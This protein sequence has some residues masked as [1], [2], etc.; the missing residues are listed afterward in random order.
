VLEVGWLLAS[1][2]RPGQTPLRVI[3]NTV[4]EAS[5]RTRVRRERFGRE[6][7]RLRESTGESQAGA[8]AAIGMDRSFYA[9]VEA[10]RN[11]VSLDK[12]FTIADHYGVT[13]GALLDGI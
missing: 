9:G 7:R 2:H 10:G 8:A 1:V 6:L 3:V 5:Q 11:N 13:A 12:L 4:V